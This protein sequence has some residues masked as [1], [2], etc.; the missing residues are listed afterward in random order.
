VVQTPDGAFHSVHRP[1]DDY[2]LW[3]LVQHDLHRPLEVG[4]DTDADGIVR[5]DYKSL[6]RRSAVSRFFF[7]DRVEP[8]TKSELAAAQAS[9]HQLD[10]SSQSTSV[11]QL[12]RTDQDEIES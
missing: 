11:A 1:L 9:H 5:S 10:H 6:K 7:E 3:T 4:S 8:V 12:E 2:E